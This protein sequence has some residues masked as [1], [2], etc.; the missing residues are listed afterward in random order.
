MDGPEKKN[1]KA[2]S[3]NEISNGLQ[4]LLHPNSLIFSRTSP[5]TDMFSS[6]IFQGLM[7]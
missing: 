5:K 7:S 2:E 3:T 6:H 1:A 4:R